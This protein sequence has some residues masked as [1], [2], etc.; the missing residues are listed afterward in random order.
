MFFYILFCFFNWSVKQTLIRPELTL[1]CPFLLI[2]LQL[3]YIPG[4][5]ARCILNVLGS[6]LMVLSL[7]HFRKGN[8]W[9]KIIFWFCYNGQSNLSLRIFNIIIFALR[10][11]KWILISQ[12]LVCSVA[13][14][15]IDFRKRL[16]VIGSEIKYIALT[17]SVEMHQFVELLLR[18][19]VFL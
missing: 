3:I 8:T 18:V 1:L 6:F 16:R 5:L 19:F 13:L 10:I 17:W 11:K 2:L 14:T 7:N 15:V 9:P 4:I 12:R